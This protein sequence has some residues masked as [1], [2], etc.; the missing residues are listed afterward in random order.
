MKMIFENRF[1]R[2]CMIASVC[3][4]SL[5]MM[6]STSAPGGDS[7]NI[8]LNDK[9]LVEQFVLRKEAPKIIS[10]ASASGNDVIKVYYSHCGK[11]GTA[12]TLLI[13]DAQGKTLKSWSFENSQDN[14][15]NN[16]SIK[17]SEV[18][19]VQ[20]STGSDKLKLVYLSQELPEGLLLAYIEQPHVVKTSVK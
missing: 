13:K 12:R 10:F 15:K 7:F 11:V 9:L 2:T 1:V 8:Y 3:F 20:T 5:V 17:V 6:S 19:R 14:E 18:L 4:S 16:M